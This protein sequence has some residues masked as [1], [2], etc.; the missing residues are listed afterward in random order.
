MLRHF[1]GVGLALHTCM[2]PT[3][4]VNILKPS[5]RS[6]VFLFH[7]TRILIRVCVNADLLRKLSHLDS[8]LKAGYSVFLIGLV[9][10]GYYGGAE[11]MPERGHLY[12]FWEW[13]R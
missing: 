10:G 3:T 9:S 5:S 7:F 6:D 8:S 1:Q 4:V 12:K 11:K 13:V 2:P